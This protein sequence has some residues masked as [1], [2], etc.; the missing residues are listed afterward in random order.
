MTRLLVLAEGDSEELFVREL[1]AP[2]LNR[3]GIDARATGVVTKRLANGNKC[4]A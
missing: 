2:H 4:T 1:L 3:F